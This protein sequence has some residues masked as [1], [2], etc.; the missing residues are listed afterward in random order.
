MKPSRTTAI[1]L[2]K[3]AHAPGPL[4]RGPLAFGNE[5]ASL[6]RYRPKQPRPRHKPWA[7]RFCRWRETTG[8]SPRTRQCGTRRGVV[9]VAAPGR[10]G[11]PR[12]GHL[13]GGAAGLS[14]RRVVLARV[15]AAP[16]SAIPTDAACCVFTRW[17]TSREVWLN[18]VPVG[19]HEGGETPFML[20]ITEAVKAG[21]TNRLAV[22]VL[23]PK[24]EPIDGIVLAETPHRN[25]VPAGIRRRRF[26]Q[27]RR[28]HG[29]GGGASGSRPSA[30]TMCTCAR[31]GRPAA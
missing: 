8:S 12:A 25:K 20:D 27:Q 7:P 18:D 29:A 14:R 9:E 2:K 26:L 24:A 10:Q 13:P 11:R 6:P 19:G 5:R 15:H 4:G 30:L 1:D 23:N 28:H 16:E 22:R 17:I 31:I 21:R 3:P